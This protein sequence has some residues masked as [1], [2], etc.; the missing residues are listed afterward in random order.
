MP[1]NVL[2]TG[3][4]SPAHWNIFVAKANVDNPVIGRDVPDR[5][6]VPAMDA[7]V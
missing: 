7:I 4:E 6:S 5:L 3:E 2:I 1:P